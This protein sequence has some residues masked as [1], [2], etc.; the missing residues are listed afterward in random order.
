MPEEIAR[1]FLFPLALGIPGL[2]H[3]LGNILH[4]SLRVLPWWPEWQ[5]QAKAV[6]QW[7][8][9]DSHRDFLMLHLDNLPDV[10]KEARD[11]MG[12]S[13]NTFAEWRWHTLA[14]VTNDLCSREVPV[15]A[16]MGT[17]SNSAELGSRGRT[18]SQVVWQVVNRRQL[19]AHVLDFVPLAFYS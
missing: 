13:C 18:F 5:A 2:Q 12:R 8:G 4:D 6:C 19:P 7:L 10:T 11:A 9:Y 15:R 16:S 1:E 14:T 3:I 17:L